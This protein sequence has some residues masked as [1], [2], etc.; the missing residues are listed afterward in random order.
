MQHT[1]GGQDGA[2]GESPRVAGYDYDDDTVGD[3]RSSQEEEGTRARADRAELVPCGL[4]AEEGLP[5]EWATVQL[6]R[7]F[8]PF[9]AK[10]N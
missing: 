1:N 10:T 5:I 2:A 9:K 8:T 4:P 6:K 3:G 7:T